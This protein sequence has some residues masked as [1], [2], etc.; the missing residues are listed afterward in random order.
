M[1]KFIHI[2]DIHICLKDCDYSIFNIEE[3][4]L[5]ALE[6]FDKIIEICK[7]EKI[8]FLF[9]S[10]DLFD[11]EDIDYE[12][13]KHLYD[14]F[15]L[16]SDTNI[17]IA[18]GNHD[19]TEKIYYYEYS[20][21][22]SNVHIFNK[23]TFNSIM[24]NDINIIGVSFPTIL[25]NNYYS[26]ISN[27]CKSDKTNILMM[28]CPL[29]ESIYPNYHIDL[30]HKLEPLPLDYCAFGHIHYFNEYYIESNSMT[31]IH[32]SSLCD[33]YDENNKYGYIY[34][35]LSNNSINYTFIEL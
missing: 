23:T 30:K 31:I 28:H 19:S 32:S 8:D 3:K 7:K 1:K 35:E 9:I 15:F 6:K 33:I 26:Q 13:Y 10:G 20:L 22:P 4:R 17:L 25:D 24:C 16:I 34:G 12:I 2:S 14:S 18:P 11:S 27:L 29:G 5:L 21:F